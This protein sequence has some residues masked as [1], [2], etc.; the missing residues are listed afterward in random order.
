MKKLY[1]FFAMAAMAAVLLSGCMVGG[2]NV[3]RGE[4]PRVA[5]ELNVTGF[6]SL[7]INGAH[8]L[9]FR[10]GDYSAVLEIQA[11]LFEFLNAEVVNGVLHIRYSRAFTTIGRDVTPRLII[12][13]PNLYWLDVL[14]AVTGRVYVD[15]T[16]FD[17]SV[18][19][20]ANLTLRGTAE[21][22]VI[23]AAGAAKI[24]AFNLEA[25][26]VTV[27]VAG[28]AYIDVYAV[29]TLDASVSGVGTVRYD[30]DAT[31]TRRVSGIGSISRR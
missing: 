6:T 27:S 18:S 16:A 25:Q 23:T 29:Q 15:A 30:G 12:Y 7:A 8:E 14:G 17:V 20:A 9:I 28:A 21:R 5:H 11:N 3:V 13:A 2:R 22:L 31:V 1:V 24:D 26:H 4:G 19:G 10:H